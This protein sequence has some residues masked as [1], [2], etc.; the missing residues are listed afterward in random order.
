MTNCSREQRTHWYDEHY[1][2][3]GRSN[4]TTYTDIVLG[5]EYADDDSAQFRCRTA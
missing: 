5:K 2:E 1:V 3:D 4:D